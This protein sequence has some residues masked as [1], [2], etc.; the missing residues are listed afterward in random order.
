MNTT[1]LLK[2]LNVRCKGILLGIFA[3]DRLPAKLPPRRPLLIVCNTDPHDK[4]GEHWIVMYIGS[5]GVGEY[6]DSYGLYPQKVFE[7][8]IL[9]NCSTLLWN[10]KALQSVISRFCGHY[11]VFFSL[12]KV[13]E[14]EMKDIVDCFSEDTALNDV[15][16]HKFVCDNL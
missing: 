7:N 14:Y 3:R 12:F 1:E 8:Y 5:N 6:F 9:R 16:V 4:P 2:I 11:C 15:I 10:K 13:L